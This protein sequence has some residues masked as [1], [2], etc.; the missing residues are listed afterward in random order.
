MGKKSKRPSRQQKKPTLGWAARTNRALRVGSATYLLGMCETSRPH[1]A[2]LPGVQ[3][4]RRREVL[5]RGVPA[6]ALDRGRAPERVPRGAPG[7]N[8]C[9]TITTLIKTTPPP[10]AASCPRCPRRSGSAGPT[11]KRRGAGPLPGRHEPLGDHGSGFSRVEV[12]G[13]DCC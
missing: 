1:R 8:C 4:V 3:R 11:P 9:K 7:M 6:R 13:D 10:R 2:P 5:F 12:S